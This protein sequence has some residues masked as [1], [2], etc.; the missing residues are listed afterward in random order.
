MS[1]LNEVTFLDEQRVDL[2]TVNLW[3]LNKSPHR[4]LSYSS[5]GRPCTGPLPKVSAKGGEVCPKGN[6]IMWDTARLVSRTRYIL[7]GIRNCL[8]FSAKCRSCFQE[9]RAISLLKY[10]KALSNDQ[11][12]P[13]CREKECLRLRW[14]RSSYCEMHVRDYNVQYHSRPSQRLQPKAIFLFSA[15]QEDFEGTQWK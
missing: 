15:F 1:S 9:N 14:W 5:K 2:L 8:H 6:V 11:A 7:C 10:H 4:W 12:S 3:Q 13:T